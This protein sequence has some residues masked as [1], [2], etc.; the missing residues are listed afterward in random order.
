MVLKVRLYGGL[1][2]KAD[3]FDRESQSIGLLEIESD[4][5]DE[6]RDILDRLKIDHDEVSH[7][8]V[9]RE[10]SALKRMIEDGDRVAFF[11]KDMALLYKWYFSEK[12]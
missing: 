4:G 3:S 1:K 12:K 2:D 6:V 9:N 11:P 8:F 7:I 10:Y 5:I